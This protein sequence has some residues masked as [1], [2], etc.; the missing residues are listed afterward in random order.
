MQHISRAAKSHDGT[1]PHPSTG[2][3][4][5]FTKHI[6]DRVLLLH[7]KTIW[8]WIDLCH[9]LTPPR[10]FHCQIHRFHKCSLLLTVLNTPRNL[11]LALNIRSLSSPFLRLRPDRCSTDVKN[12]GWSTTSDAVSRR[13]WSTV[14]SP[15][16]RSCFPMREQFWEPKYRNSSCITCLHFKTNFM[17]SSQLSCRW[18]VSTNLLY[19]DVKDGADV[20][21]DDG[22]ESQRPLIVVSSYGSLAVLEPFSLDA[23]QA[24]INAT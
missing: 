19:P 14:S 8:A 10:S 23:E 1:P 22:W 2:P 7:N 3:F 17:P 4:F 13:S 16:T 5:S 18:T 15:R 12:H 9:V 21:D 6:V 20:G 11:A 24:Q